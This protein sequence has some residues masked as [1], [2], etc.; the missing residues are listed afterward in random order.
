M[1]TSDI[2]GTGQHPAHESGTGFHSTRYLWT[3]TYPA[4]VYLVQGTIQLMFQVLQ[5]SGED[6]NCSV[7]PQSRSTANNKYFPYM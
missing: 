4:F 1:E 5:A 7:F 2:S 3:I 6:V